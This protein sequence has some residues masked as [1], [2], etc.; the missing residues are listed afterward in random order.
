MAHTSIWPAIETLY[1][2]HFATFGNIRSM[3]HEPWSKIHE[4]LSVSLNL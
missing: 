2:S 3:T 1:Q 4:I